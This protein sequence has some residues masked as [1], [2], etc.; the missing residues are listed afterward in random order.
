MDLIQKIDKSRHILLEMLQDRGYDTTP[1]Q[2][3]TTDDINHMYNQ[4][5]R[6]KSS[7]S[8]EPGSLDMILEKKGLPRT[9]IKYRLDKYRANK[10]ILKLIDRIYSPDEGELNPDDTLVLI[11]IEGIN[12]MIN[13]EKS[14]ESLYDEYGYYI[15]VFNLDV[16]QNNITKMNIVPK[17]RILS[18]EE[19]QKLLEK[20]SIR[21]EDL[22]N[23]KRLDPMAKYYAM[24]PGE[25]CEIHRKTETSGIGHYF[26]HCVQM[27]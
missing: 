27:S 26:R 4:F 21:E 9:Y 13:L 2:N 16:L 11:V 24:K 5:Q 25:I 22:P 15:Q 1:Y 19:K 6:S 12:Q 20:Y 3:F 7:S 8:S 17:H 23:I 10:P 18:P 14:L